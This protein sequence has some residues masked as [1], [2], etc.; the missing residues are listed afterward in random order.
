MHRAVAAASPPPQQYQPAGRDEQ[1][2]SV[3]QSIARIHEA[4]QA[5]P[6]APP[7]YRALFE[8]MAQEISD[9]GLTGAQTLT[10]I[11]E[12]AQDRGINVRREDVQFILN[13]VS[14]ADPWYEQGAS[15]VLFAGRFRN[16]VV[17]RC[18]AQGLNLSADEL[19]LVDAWF[20]GGQMP[21]ATNLRAS[22]SQNRDRD[23]DIA[24]PVQQRLTAPQSP[25]P[26]PAPAEPRGNRWW[27]ADDAR[28]S[29]GAQRASAQ[30]SDDDFPRIVRTRQRG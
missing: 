5:P 10:S 30:A 17:T 12:R 25:P 16:H 19:D 7:E 9:N 8:V 4:C 28:P 3:Q 23:R 21:Q 29:A 11:T 2:P 13:A 22:A 14:E 20:T 24:P 18:R 15:A 26:A 1:P 27:S 6:L